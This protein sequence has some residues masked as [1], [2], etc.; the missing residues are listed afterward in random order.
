MGVRTKPFFLSREEEAELARSNKKV[1]DV[2]HAGFSQG[3]GAQSPSPSPPPQQDRRHDRR[4][5]RINSWEKSQE[6]I[7][8]LSLL[9]TKWKLTL[10]Q[11]GRCKS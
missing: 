9:A 5:L 11:M 8:V 4:P 3:P 1:K 2:H 7:L 6:H 10:T